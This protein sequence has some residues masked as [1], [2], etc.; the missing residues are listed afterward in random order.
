MSEEDDA[1]AGHRLV[2]P[3][4]RPGRSEA[5]DSVVMSTNE[6]AED[7]QT[8]TVLIRAM[9]QSDLEAVVRIDAEAS[10]RRRLR[11]FELMLERAVQNAALQVSLTAVVDG[12]VAGY[13]IGSLYYG[14]YG[15]TEPNASIDAVGVAAD[16]RRQGVGQALMRQFRANVGAI[17]ATVIRTEVDWDDFDLLPFF[18][19]EGFAPSRRICLELSCRDDV[20][21]S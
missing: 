20:R 21:K 10:G 1:K 2:C 18:H 5:T 16:R 14:E 7:L 12:A 17:G 8:E 4:T 19:S 6:L 9:R 3:A 11:Y 15:L 13:L